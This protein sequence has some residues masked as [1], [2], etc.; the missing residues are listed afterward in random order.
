MK[1]MTLCVWIAVLCGNKVMVSLKDAEL[2][3]EY[4][5]EWRKIHDKLD[6]VPESARKYFWRWVDEENELRDVK[7]IDFRL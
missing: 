2:F 7:F 3:W 5:V 4:C 6:K 1:A